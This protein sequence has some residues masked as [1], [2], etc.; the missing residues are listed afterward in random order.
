MFHGKLKAVTFSYDDGTT[1][2]I[3]LIELLNHYHLKSTFNLNSGLMGK[4][5]EL[6]LDG[7]CIPHNKIP[8]SDI[9][10]IYKGHEIA[11][12]TLTHPSLPTLSDW[13]IIHEVERDRLN[14]SEIAGYEVK[15]MAYPGGGVN[16]D[17]RV[18]S[19][20]K[21]HTH[22]RYART[23]GYTNSFDIQTDLYQF[24]PN[25]LH[26]KYKER[27]FRLAEQ[28][29]ALTPNKPQIFYI[30]GHS[31]EFDWLDAW[32]DIE[33]F[34]KLISNRNDIFYG[35]NSEILLSENDSLM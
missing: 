24:T 27:L 22:V 1:Q 9:A 21:T 3:R 11:V 5:G 34:F 17:D 16:H 23:N 10:S 18:A 20:I 33:E 12:H 13:E 29:L 8:K 25:V 31:F 26:I 6:L 35:T 4:S 15:G 28:F 7:K 32:E 2:D 14:L 19:L 30:W